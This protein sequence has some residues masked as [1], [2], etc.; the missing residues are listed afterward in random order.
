MERNCN[1]CKAEFK[2]EDEVVFALNTLYHANCYDGNPG[3]IELEGTYEVISETYL[4]DEVT[5]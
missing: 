1:I 4:N 3:L 2:K 5:Q